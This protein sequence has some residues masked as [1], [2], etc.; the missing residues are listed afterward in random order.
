[1]KK[2][3]SNQRG[4]SLTLVLVVFLVLSVFAAAIINVTSSDHK[5][6]LYQERNMQAYYLA[7]SG[8]EAVAQ[9]I[10]DKP[11]EINN[12]LEKEGNVVGENID[13]EVEKDSDNIIIES[14]ATVEFGKGTTSET[15]VI[16]LMGKG[17]EGESVN[18]GFDYAIATRGNILGAG[19]ING[20]VRTLDGNRNNVEPVV[21][22]EVD[23]GE[24]IFPEIPSSTSF[25]ED[26]HPINEEQLQLPTPTWPPISEKKIEYPNHSVFSNWG[27]GAGTKVIIDTGANKNNVLFIKIN[28]L[29]NIG[30]ALAGAPID[31]EVTGNGTLLLETNGFQIT[32][33]HASIRTTGNTKV[34]LHNRS[35]T[36][37]LTVGG[38]GANINIINESNI[39]T[40]LNTGGNLTGSIYAKGDVR[41]QSG[42]SV[43][44]PS[45]GN[46]DGDLEPIPSGDATITYS[47]DRKVYIN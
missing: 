16:K 19:V 44:H 13:I 21:N 25:D 2:Y 6:T 10:I 43:T 18:S 9:R 11:D 26:I 37:Q 42:S 15:V 33:A 27:L 38:S 40:L 41:I 5:E 39:E 24:V 35:N 17:S 28:N 7:R 47:H 14:T 3:F 46:E 8:A 1:M 31:I 45:F 30:A 23:G 22:G 4:A 34:I 36:V 20:N 32:N 12:I 29:V